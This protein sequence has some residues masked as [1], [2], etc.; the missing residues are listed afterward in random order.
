MLKKKLKIFENQD[1]YTLHCPSSLLQYS[2]IL[3]YFVIDTLLYTYMKSSLKFVGYCCLGEQVIP[4]PL[5]A[6]FALI[7]SGTNDVYCYNLSLHLSLLSL[8]FVLPPVYMYILTYWNTIK[9]RVV[10]HSYL[11]MYVQWKF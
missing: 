7:N 10:S 4:G 2:Y 5:V 9:S 6:Y 8:L 3:V 11:Y 1:I